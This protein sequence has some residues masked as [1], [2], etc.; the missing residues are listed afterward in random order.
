MATLLSPRQRGYIMPIG[1]IVMIPGEAVR[2]YALLKSQIQFRYSAT[3][4]S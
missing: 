2:G 1:P 4:T 3:L